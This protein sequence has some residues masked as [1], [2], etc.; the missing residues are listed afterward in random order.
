M[1]QASRRMTAG[2]YQPRSKGAAMADALADARRSLARLIQMLIMRG[3]GILLFLCAT[4]A[5]LA[6]VSYDS[7]DASLNN[8]TGVEPS[9]L[10]GGL[11]ATA[12]DLLLQAFG[13]AAIAALAPPMVWGLR[14]LRGR[15]LSHTMG[16][17]LARC[18]SR[19]ALEFFPRR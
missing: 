19:L 4:A 13:I 7:R 5:L 10:L 15:H 18:C 8:A 3:A 1:S 16:R 14:A 11:G 12:A 6:L 2:V 17:A 9:N